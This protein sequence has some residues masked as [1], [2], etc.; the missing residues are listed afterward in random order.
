MGLALGIGEDPIDWLALCA[1]WILNRTL[2][3]GSSDRSPGALFRYLVTQ[4]I[5]S[6]IN[7]AVFSGIVMVFGAGA[8]LAP[9][10]VGAAAGLVSN[11]LMSKYAV[12]SER[13]RM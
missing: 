7:L 13:P 9:L 10:A 5:G 8:L 4:S 11:I 12:F 2:T 6:A 1:R 3:F